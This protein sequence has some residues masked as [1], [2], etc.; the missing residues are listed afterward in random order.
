MV[1]TEQLRFVKKIDRQH[2]DAFAKKGAKIGNSINIRKPVK[3]AI[4]SGATYSAGDTTETQSTLTLDKQRGVDM[5]FTSQE[6]TL[7]LDDFSRRIIKP[8][9]AS[10]ASYIDADALSMYQAV[11]NQVGTPGTTPATAA[12]ILSAGKILNHE[13]CP[14]SDR[15]MLIDPDAQ[16]ALVNA[17]SSL[18]NPARDIGRQYTSG[19]MAEA[20]G[21]MFGMTQNINTHTVGAHGGTPVINGAS[22][23]GSSLVTDGWTAS[24]AILKK[25]DIFTIANVYA[26]VNP[27]GGNA[28]TLTY[29]RQFVVTAD[30]S[31]D[32]SGNATIPIYPAIAA[33]GTAQTVSALPADGAAI[34]VAGTAST[35]YPINLGFHEEAFTLGT[36]DLEVPRGVD[37]AHRE[38]HEGISMRIVRQYDVTDDK[39]KTR[40]DVIYGFVA[41]RP[42]LAIRLIG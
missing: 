20:L 19:E 31:A 22:Q 18:Q 28:R 41:Q 6:L 37:M 23:T 24:A 3:Y 25:G 40:V 32:G 39:Y 27:T 33:T 26:A 42:E 12:V 29:L 2:D 13:A 36:A 34:T 16:A 21:F 1:L 8:A 10:L 15:Q 11:S 17:L 35:A 14:E 30:T 4:R 38:V 9:M 7:D 5:E